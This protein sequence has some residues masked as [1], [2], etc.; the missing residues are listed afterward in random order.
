MAQGIKKIRFQPQTSGANNNNSEFSPNQWVRIP[1]NKKALFCVKEWHK[2]STLAQKKGSIYWMV[3]NHERTKIISR[4]RCMT[5]KYFVYAIPK[6]LCGEVYYI[7][8]SMSGKPDVDFTGLMVVGKSPALIIT[9]AW[10]RSRGSQNLKNT[11]DNN[12][13]LCYGD[14][15]NFHANTEGINGKIVTVEVHN[16]MWAGDYKM[17]TL[18][19]V[20]VIDGQINLKITNT[21]QWISAIKDI[22]DNEEFYV[23]IIVKG[24]GYLKDKGGNLEH[25]KYL[26]IKKL[27][28]K[29]AV[30]KPPQNQVA[31]LVDNTDKNIIGIGACKFKQ[32]TINDGTSVSVFNEGKTQLKKGKASYSEI[33]EYVYFDFDKNTVRSDAMNKLNVL[34][35]KL[36]NNR[37]STVIIEGHAD[38]R[39]PGDY[40]LRL[41]QNRSEAVATYLK[42][43]IQDKTKFQPQGLGENHLIYKGSNLTPAQH[44]QNRR[45]KIRFSVTDSDENSLI[46]EVIAPPKGSKNEK[47]IDITVSDFEI[48]SCINQHIKKIGITDIGQVKDGNE[49]LQPFALPTIKYTIYSE[50]SK[51]NLLPLQYIFPAATTPNKLFLDVHSCT[52]FSNKTIPTAII[53]I[54]PDIKWQFDLSLNLSN[55]LSVKWQNLSAAKH[56]KMQSAA[57][58]IGAEKRWKQTEIDFGV[59]LEANWDKVS[60]D[61]YNS[62]FD[63]TSKYEEKIKAFYKVF[64][65]V[66]EFS[67]GVTDVTKGKIRKNG[68]L[69]KLPLKIEMKPPN[70]CLGAEWMLERGKLNNKELNTLG[71]YIK[72]YFK[73]EPLIGIDFTIDLLD[74]LI[75]AGVGVVSGGTANIAAKAILQDVRDWLADDDHPITLKMYIDLKLYGTISGT[76]ELS[77]NTI[78]DTAK[79]NAKLT[80]KIGVEL[81]A[82]IEL[83][84][85]YVIVIAE[86]YVEGKIKATG[87]AS[88]TFAHELQFEQKTSSEKS[89]Y[90]VP[91]LKFDGL[92]ATVIVKASV[93]LSIKKGIFK[94]DR[95]VDLV[96]FKDTYKIIPEF[97]VI[98]KLE[99]YA[100]VS[101]KIPLI[102]KT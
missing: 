93:G 89:L 13:G 37:H 12:D 69:S 66:K 34:A 99:K 17:R 48:K 29:G 97:D 59:M 88:V 41:S 53:R 85:S 1:A 39:G 8:A 86:A 65:S 73:A 7:E 60:E 10:T 90:Y 72:F 5:N 54:F 38:E 96:D 11:N 21:A 44:Q 20:M 50:L 56:K 47:K 92:V 14:E 64:G 27:K 77:V 91:G 25:G 35:S 24:G 79:G 23:K 46:Y 2:E 28:R 9:S 45:A 101:A 43:K 36:K 94:G 18:Y 31:L 33:I 58:K 98:K 51:I 62:H 63:A 83:K 19:N 70:F 55:D 30:A 84:A 75:Q 61:Q 3:M 4:L 49:K 102:Q 15:I 26:N 95:K 32:I 78:S 57:G 42:Q 16:E 87:K 22:Q 81:D 74:M 82:G 6:H 68:F 80:S 40:N 76:S 52:Y 71:T 100:G 67:K